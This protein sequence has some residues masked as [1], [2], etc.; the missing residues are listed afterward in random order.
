MNILGK[1]IIIGGAVDK[2]SFTETNLDKNAV[3][4]LN[5]FETGILKRIINESKHKE[6]SRIEVITTASVIPKEIGPEYIKAFAYLNAKNID[7][8]DIVRREQASDETILNRL[9]AADI[10][11]FTGGDQLRLSS[12]LG[13]TPFH[14]ILLDKYHNEEFIYA[15]T[16]AG[17]AA[18]SNNMIYQGSSSEALLKGEVKISSGLGLIDGVI[19]DT[20]FVQRGRIGRLFQAVVG[21]PRILGIGLG[22]D[23]GLLITNNK[24][25]EA[26]G[27]GLVI[28]VDGREIKDTNLTQVELGQPISISHL[29][30]HVMSKFDTYNLETHK[31][32][33]H[34]SQYT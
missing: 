10:V 11:M 16:S 31:M 4:N 24:D 28:L 14:D 29:V 7:I 30:T 13:G 12:I 32:H 6:N 15:G 20:H 3:S 18:A 33:I 17:A 22:E 26:I 25:M 9:K 23:T 8:L 27:S 5:F 1:L 21:N 34:S 19:I 2:G